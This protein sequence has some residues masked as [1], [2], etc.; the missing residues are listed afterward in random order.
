MVI[1]PF[2]F[3]LDFS[4]SSSESVKSLKSE[5]LKSESL[6]SD[7][8]S[9]SIFLHT[10]LTGGSKLFL[11]TGFSISKSDSDSGSLNSDNESDSEL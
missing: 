7:N 2:I 11:S 5:S 6:K 3:C 9:S 8:K 4:N 10:T 1:L